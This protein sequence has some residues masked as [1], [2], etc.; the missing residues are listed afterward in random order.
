MTESYIKGEK[1]GNIYYLQLNRP[2]KRNAIP[3]EMLIEICELVDELI[4]DPEIRA[5]ILTGEGKVFSA[6]VDF[7]S[8]AMLVERFL[9]DS[10]AGGAPIRADIHKYQYYLNRLE[11]IEIPIICAMHGSALG[12]S[13]ELALV[14]DIRLMSD[15]C[16]WGM[17]ELQF[18]VIPDLGGTARL[19]K[20]LGTAR[21]MEILATGRKYTAQQALDW[22]LVNYVYPEPQLFI[23]A[24]NLANDIA[25]MAPLAVGALKKVMRRGEGVDLMTQLD[26]EANLQSILLRSDDFQEGVKAMMEQRAPDWKRK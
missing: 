25:K 10:S 1:K 12:M 13:M 11:T 5:I 18:G 15:D 14:C 16:Q 21:A 4:T 26:M 8:L 20:V 9:V 19:S 17:Q 7:E 3:F 24:E 2:E 23:E 6:G 22:G